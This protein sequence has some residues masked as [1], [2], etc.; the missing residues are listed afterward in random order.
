[1]S[2]PRRF[3]GV[4]LVVFECVESEPEFKRR[5]VARGARRIFAD[6]AGGFGGGFEHFVHSGDVF[7]YALV[8]YF[9]QLFLTAFLPRY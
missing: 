9:W 2:E 8:D 4:L 1:M 5:V 3:L 6:G 7:S